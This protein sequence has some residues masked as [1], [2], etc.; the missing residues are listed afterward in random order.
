MSSAAYN[1]TIFINNK[2]YFNQWQHILTCDHCK[3]FLVNPRNCTNC[4]KTF[5]YNCMK[6][7][8]VRENMKVLCPDKGCGSIFIRDAHQD[9]LQKLEKLNISCYMCSNEVKYTEIVDHVLLTCEKLKIQ[10]FNPGCEQKIAKYHMDAHLLSCDFGITNCE[11]CGQNTLRNQLNKIIDSKRNTINEKNTEI[12]Q[13]SQ[14][15][16]NLKDTLES[17]KNE[18]ANLKKENEK[19]RESEES[20]ESLQIK[21]NKLKVKKKSKVLSE[22]ISDMLQSI[23]NNIEKINPSNVVLTVTTIIKTTGKFLNEKEVKFIFSKLLSYHKKEFIERVSYSIETLIGTILETH[24]ELFNTK[25]DLTHEFVSTFLKVYP[26]ENN[27]TDLEVIKGLNV[28]IEVVRNLGEFITDIFFSDMV[29]IPLRLVQHKNPTIRSL[30]FTVLEALAIH[31]ETDFNKYINDVLNALIAAVNYS[32]DGQ[33]KQ[34][35]AHTKDD[36]IS[37]MG[38][39]IYMRHTN[40][41]VNF[42]IPQWLS[43]FSLESDIILK[44]S[45][46]FLCRFLVSEKSE[47]LYGT[48]C[49]NL[50]TII[51]ILS[52]IYNTKKIPV[53]SKKNIETFFKKIK[54]DVSLHEYV[55]LAKENFEAKNLEVLLPISFP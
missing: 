16:T 29:K 38:S 14:E 4:K 43:Y 40:L 31:S 49:Q 24:S 48:N 46:G 5:C 25:K 30:C 53:V 20:K 12:G 22:V 2:V 27:S 1:S 52:K 36:A 35:W 32:S 33:D 34:V 13:L 19:L 21:I 45:Y 39:I 23:D 26:L 28:L 6:S 9:T 37:G 3:G 51:K 8:D 7:S 44:K 17:V 41:D 50:P 18:N 11:E 47:V 10:C 54:D 55:K 42:W 15:I